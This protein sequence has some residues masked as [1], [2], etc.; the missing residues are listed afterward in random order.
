MRYLGRSEGLFPETSVHGRSLHLGKKALM[1][2]LLESTPCVAKGQ[3]AP[4]FA[5]FGPCYARTNRSL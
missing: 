2:G 5:L 4:L 1:L 3:K